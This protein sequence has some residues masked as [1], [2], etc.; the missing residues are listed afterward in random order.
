MVIFCSL[1]VATSFADDV[2]DAV[3]V[4][5]ERDLDLRHAARRRRQPDQLEASERAVVARHLAL[6]LQHVH[7]DARLVVG[8]RREDLA[9]P[10]RDRRV[11]RDERRH[12][13]AQRLDA[14]RQRR[15][16]EQQ[17][18]LD[19]A[20]RARRPGSPR[21]PRRLRQDSRPCAVPCRTCSFTSCWIFGMRVEPP[22]STTSSMSD[23]FTPASASACFSGAIERSQQIV[24]ELLELR[25]RQLHLQ[26]L[27]AGLIG[28]D[29]RQVDVGLHH[30][31]E[32]DLGL[33][34]R[35]LQALQRPSGPCRDRRRRSS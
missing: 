25:A 6:A 7:F 16:V 34:R 28:R 15:H 2:D 3:G 8:R 18:V 13:A 31:G 27:R 24:D 4:D 12:H 10:R 14:E 17:H 30:R 22:T 11:A 20:R 21:R 9:L 5:V 1:P 29:E 35:F 33:L 32:L 23:G 26:V 19:F